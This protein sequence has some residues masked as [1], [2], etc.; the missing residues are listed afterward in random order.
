MA[1]VEASPEVRNIVY[2]GDRF[3]FNDLKVAQNFSK[4]NASY[5]KSDAV[6]I[7]RQIPWTFRQT[8]YCYTFREPYDFFCIDSPFPMSKFGDITLKAYTSKQAF[9]TAVIDANRRVS[10]LWTAPITHRNV[11]LSN[12]LKRPS[13]AMNLTLSGELEFS[14]ENFEAIQ[15]IDMDKI[16][17]SKLIFNVSAKPPDGNSSSS[18]TL[19]PGVQTTTAEAPEA[20]E[21]FTMLDQI[22]P[23]AKEQDVSLIDGQ[24]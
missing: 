15:D 20:V 4:I 24:L 22:Q 7:G 18:N 13:S 23:R 11:S 6:I 8:K 3:S 5:A 19:D 1:K 10:L 16:V 12:M 14:S 2:L 21:D 9:F 17:G